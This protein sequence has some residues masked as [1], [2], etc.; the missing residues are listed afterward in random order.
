MNVL[1]PQKETNLGIFLT[2]KRYHFPCLDQGSRQDLAWVDASATG[3]NVLGDPGIFLPGK[4]LK[5]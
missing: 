5:N 2:P 1:K 4:S 3:V